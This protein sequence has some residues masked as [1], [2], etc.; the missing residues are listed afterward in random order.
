MLV[1]SMNSKRQRRPN[2]RLGEIGD[3]SAAFS[4]GISGKSSADI[5]ENM[6]E[7]DFLIQEESEYNPICGFSQ[8]GLSQLVVSDPGVNPEIPVDMQQNREKNNPDS[9]TPFL[10]FG[11]VDEVGA[12]KSKLNLGTITRKCRLMKRQRRSRN[13]S[14]GALGGSWNLKTSPEISNGD[15]KENEEEKVDGFTSNGCL[16]IHH[17]DGFK[18][19]SCYETSGTVKEDCENDADEATFHFQG[20][21]NPPSF[22]KVASYSAG[23]DAFH[24]SFGGCD[25]EKTGTCNLN[26]VRKW[27]EELGFGKYAGIFEMHEVDEEA[28]PLLTLED[29]KEMGVLA[30]GPRRKLYS[31]IQQLKEGGERLMA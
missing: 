2:V 21:G 10:E 6:W 27:L 26:N 15:G 12:S 1:L 8:Q 30:V 7:N 5:A 4:C 17:L 11:S 28:L 24:Q 31:A 20:Q 16:D 29:L 14:F 9:L 19:S 23:N 3:V 18:D 25:V 22:W 13:S